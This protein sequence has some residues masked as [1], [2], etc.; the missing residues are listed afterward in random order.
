MAT[1][2][3]RETVARRMVRAVRFGVAWLSWMAALAGSGRST[4]VAFAIPRHSTAGQ[5]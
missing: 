5:V 1:S 2:G 4:R 3:F